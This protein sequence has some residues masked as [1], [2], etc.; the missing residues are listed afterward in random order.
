VLKKK[1]VARVED[2]MFRGKIDAAARHLSIPISFVS[3]AEDL[4]SACKDG[5]AAVFVELTP[6]A[7]EA[8]ARLKKSGSGREVPVIG[9]LAHVDTKLAE[10]ARAKSV[11]RVLSRAQFSE[12][13]PDLLLEF[14]APGIE[15]TV[16]EE[17]ELPE[18]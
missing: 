15:R 10:E 9:F 6:A 13:L 8:V 18:E 3:P 12:T 1:I 17:P 7:L 11:D 4:P 2:L 5:P 14:M 16:E